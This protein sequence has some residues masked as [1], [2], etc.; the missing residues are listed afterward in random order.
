MENLMRL[1]EETAAVSVGGQPLTVW[2]RAQG[3]AAHLD[4]PTVLA[5]AYAVESLL[6]GHSK[7]VY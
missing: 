6:A 4:E 5:R 3:F 2:Y 1:K 7:Y